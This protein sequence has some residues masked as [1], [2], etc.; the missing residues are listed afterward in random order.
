MGCRS[1]PACQT[2][3]GAS[4]IHRQGGTP[5]DRMVSA[6]A[7]S[8]EV[9]AVQMFPMS[10]SQGNP[11][12]LPLSHGGRPFHL[13]LPP[14]RHLCLRKE[15][16]PYAFCALIGRDSSTLSSCVQLYCEFGPSGMNQVKEPLFA[17][18]K[19]GGRNHRPG[20]PTCRPRLCPREP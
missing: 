15:P 3:L 7:S 20:M 4:V 14:C 1:F 6:C 16:K 2:D 18:A 13:R 10:T 12:S 11:R 8:G 19:R 5:R 9:V 17:N